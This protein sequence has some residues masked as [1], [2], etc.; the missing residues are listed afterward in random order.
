VHTLRAKYRLDAVLPSMRCVGYRQA[1]ETIEGL[2]PA[3]ELRDR[4]I[5]ATRQFAKRQL[6][7]LNHFKDV[8]LLD[9]Q[10]PGLAATITPTIERFVAE[11]ML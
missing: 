9:C 6:T 3:T 11:H 2:L 1:W 4:G 10:Q 5:F 8:A 7:W